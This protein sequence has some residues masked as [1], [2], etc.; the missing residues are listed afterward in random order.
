MVLQAGRVKQRTPRAYERLSIHDQ[1]NLWA[2][3]ADTPMHIMA[4]LQLEPEPFVGADGHLKLDEIHRRIARRM[5]QAPRLRQ[6]VRR[7][8]VLTGPPVWIDEVGFDLSRHVRAGT[9]PAP[10]G[11]AELLQVVAW[12][13][14][15]LLDRSHP[16]W[17]LWLLTGL[18][19]GRLVMVLKLHHA[20]ADGLAA[21][22]LMAALFD[23]TAD[24]RGDDA[25]AG[26][27]QPETPPGPW[28][29]MRDNVASKARRLAR[30]LALTRRPVDVWRAW[31]STVSAL[32]FMV[33]QASRAP[34][35]SINRP[36]GPHRRLAVIRIP[37]DEAKRVAHAHGGKVND[38]LLVLV[39]GG[40][41]TLLLE[42]GERIDGLE[43][44]A[45]VP[46]SMRHDSKLGNE[47]GTMLVPLPIGAANAAERLE[48][49][50][51]ATAGAKRAQSAAAESMAFSLMARLGLARRLSRHQ[52]FVN[53]FITNVPGPPMPV[54]V[55]SSRLFDIIPVTPIAGNCTLGFGAL[56]YS[57][58][59]AIA[60]VAD[61]DQVPDVDVVMRGMQGSWEAL[62]SQRPGV[63]V[64]S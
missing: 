49:V 42:R 39:A 64:A 7:G 19:N 53:L 15:Q 11:E 33:A 16:L 48:V 41:R 17:Q 54:D 10:G 52:R 32:R 44:V 24:G 21:A 22:Q 30:G 2:E 31:G 35:C 38:L 5:D 28:S 20:I 12:I 29:L 37:L 45:S 1:S 27:W 50:A 3:A 23:F 58:C 59:L 13:D 43:L 61:A 14:E 47:V 51:A 63:E 56:S 18:S 8:S 46:V 25:P 4:V 60:A 6:L 57:G 40:V 9:I 36:I 34:R 26:R 55:L 62:R